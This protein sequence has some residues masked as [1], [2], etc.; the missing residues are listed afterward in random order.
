MLKELLLVELARHIDKRTVKADYT[1]GGS[2][3]QASLRRSLIDGKIVRKHVYL[4]QNDP[5]GTVTR[6]RLL[7]ENG[8]VLAERN[9]QK[10]HEEGK[11]LL[12]EFKF[13]IQEV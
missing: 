8:E 5:Y 6:C 2:T 3:Y 4:T 11:G 10:V 13:I 7:G 1:I 12:L 9:D